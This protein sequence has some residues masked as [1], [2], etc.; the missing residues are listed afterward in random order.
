MREGRSK[1]KTLKEQVYQELRKSIINGDFSN[2][3]FTEADLCEKFK[4]STPPVREAL[5]ELSKDNFIK[6]IPRHGYTITP[7]SVKEALDILDVRMDIE[8]NQWER[9]KLILTDKKINQFKRNIPKQIKT[10]TTINYA[11][12]YDRTMKFHL[13]LCELGENDCATKSLEAVFKSYSR[14]FRFYY[15][16]AISDGTEKKEGTG[17]HEAMLH[18]LEE[19]DYNLFGTL[20]KADIETVKEKVRKLLVLEN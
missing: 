12:H 3:I 17:Y 20:L 6:S 14:F 5:I 7:C 2:K 13:S 11:F 15:E 19:H 9:T 8:L 1:N 18:A 10:R 16:N 4:V